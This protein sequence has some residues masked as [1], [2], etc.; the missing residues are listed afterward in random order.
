VKTL[1]SIL[2]VM[3]FSIGT[4]LAK[5]IPLTYPIA[6]VG[7]DGNIYMTDL[8]DTYAITEDA[9]LS[10]N[11]EPTIFYSNP[12][13]S[14]D[15]KH[16]AF[17]KNNGF[18]TVSTGSGIS[19][20]GIV[21]VSSGEVPKVILDK[22]D[23][24]SFDSS[25]L[26]LSSDG[27]QIAFYGWQPN[28]PA[29]QGIYA[30]SRNT[31]E[32]IFIERGGSSSIGEH[33][34]VDPAIQK[35]L[36][37]TGASTFRDQYVLEWRENVIIASPVFDSNIGYMTG[38]L[39]IY[40]SE[41]EMQQII[42]GTH[43]YLVSADGMHIVAESIDGWVQIDFVTGEYNRLDLPETAKPIGWIDDMLYYRIR[44]DTISVT[45]NPDQLDGFEIYEWIWGFEATSSVLTIYVYVPDDADVLI[46]RLQG[47]D[48]G[49]IEG[50]NINHILVEY[51]SSSVPT[52]LALNEG[53]TANE[54]R[55]LQARRQAVVLR[56]S[57]KEAGAIFATPNDLPGADAAYGSGEFV[58][59][60]P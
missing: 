17:Y 5:Q 1:L 4:V 36:S 51:V 35:L 31:G 13:W 16:L 53:A 50:P 23:G 52:V 54:V 20:E 25:A 12:Q 59:S 40:S 21:V 3:T 15:G 41:G 7:T 44:S 27:S 19:V 56:V 22:S 48:I 46:A 8:T 45:G 38:D 6:Y 39:S 49:W 28:Q 57:Y 9:T 60:D 29:Q 47:Y 34:P 55:H 10:N 32:V 58:V 11:Q 42:T 33:N 18:G 2:I 26:A 30:M 14:A 43:N 24:Y 37:I